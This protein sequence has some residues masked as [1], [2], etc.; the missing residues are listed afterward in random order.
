MSVANKTGR[1]RLPIDK[2]CRTYPKYRKNGRRHGV[3][4]LPFS[5]LWILYRT[6]KRIRTG[7]NDRIKMRNLLSSVYFGK[8]K[9]VIND[10]R[11]QAGLEAKSKEDM[12]RAELAGRL[13]GRK[14]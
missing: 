9:D 13:A 7:T 10:L 1:G 8:T 12:L 14:G 6:S 3:S 2:H 4:S 5:L 11:S